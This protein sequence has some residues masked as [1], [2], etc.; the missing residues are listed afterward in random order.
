MKRFWNHKGLVE[1][2][3]FEAIASNVSAFFVGIC[4]CC[5]RDD[6]F[7]DVL[8]IQSV[9]DLFSPLALPDVE[10]TGVS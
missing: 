4:A 9:L 6:M 3:D 1:F 10:V 2:V 5:N 8:W 7:Y